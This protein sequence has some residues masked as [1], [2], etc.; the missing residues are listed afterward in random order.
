M[1]A[2]TAKQAEFMSAT[3][4]VALY[5]GETRIRR[6][7]KPP[8]NTGKTMVLNEMTVARPQQLATAWCA[9]RVRI[10]ISSILNCRLIYKYAMR[11]CMLLYI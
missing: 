5:I 6:Q 4:E 3:I 8:G 7:P 10:C 11:L 1:P 9:C 2:G